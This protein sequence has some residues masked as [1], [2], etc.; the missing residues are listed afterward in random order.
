RRHTRFKCDWSSDVCSS[1][2]DA[3]AS[4]TCNAS[5]CTQQGTACQDSQTVATCSVDSSGCPYV[6]S[7]AMCS[8]PKSCAG[9]APTAACSL[10]C[11]NSCSP[12]QTSC[13]SGGL[14]TCSLGSNGC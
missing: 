11:T 10:T 9:T 3:G 2:L 1:D 12:G 6:A 14:A 8:A 5:L 4:C 13:V 7:T